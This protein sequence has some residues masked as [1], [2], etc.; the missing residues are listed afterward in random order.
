[1]LLCLTLC[2]HHV[3]ERSHDCH[4]PCSQHPVTA[5]RELAKLSQ[6]L[7]LALAPVS[8]CAHQ[9]S[10][11]RSRL[12]HRTSVVSCCGALSTW[13][14]QSWLRSSQH[15]HSRAG[16]TGAGEEAAGGGSPGP[17]KPGCAACMQSHCG[18]R[19]QLQ[20]ARLC[21]SLG[22]RPRHTPGVLNLAGVLHPAGVPVCL[23]LMDN[24]EESQGCDLVRRPESAA[25]LEAW[26]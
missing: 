11:V 10:W 15:P 14:T 6:P 1:M 9:R 21:G 25:H 17:V 13:A 8:M 7:P 12:P 4:A 16:A 5:H 3:I 26:V 22:T 24:E 23:E 20:R 2:W 19:L 18:S